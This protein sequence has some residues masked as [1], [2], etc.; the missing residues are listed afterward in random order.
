M[1]QEFLQIAYNE[2][3]KIWTSTHY[4]YKDL[5]K[6]SLGEKFLKTMRSIEPSK[7]IDHFYDTNTEKTARE[8]YEQSIK[9]AKNL[10]RL[11]VKKGDI[12]VFFCMNNE[13]V[14]VLTMGCI[15]IGALINYFEV[16]LEDGKR[17]LL[18]YFKLYIKF[19]SNL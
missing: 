8:V 13:H 16:H 7:V 3:E 12:V 19:L 2:N 11:G 18:K 10:Q 4:P 5:V 9:V 6:G 15:L 17:V 14:A 1:V